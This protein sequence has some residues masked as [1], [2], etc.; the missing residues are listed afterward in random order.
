MKYRPWKEGGKITG[1]TEGV[2]YVLLFV[3][4]V[5]D[6]KNE[7]GVRLLLVNWVDNELLLYAKVEAGD[8]W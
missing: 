7:S 6:T 4:S 3:R 5:K 1:Y 8:R 2:M